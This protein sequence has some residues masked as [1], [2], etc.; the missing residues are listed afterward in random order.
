MGKSEPCNGYPKENADDSGLT[1]ILIL[2]PACLSDKSNIH[3]PEI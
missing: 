2:Y 1:L 3:S